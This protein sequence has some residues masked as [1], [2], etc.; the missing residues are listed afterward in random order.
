MRRTRERFRQNIAVALRRFHPA[1][2]ESPGRHVFAR[3]VVVEFD[4]LRACPVAWVADD[5][6]RTGRVREDWR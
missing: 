6:L 3:V 2:V 4:V 5:G 1:V